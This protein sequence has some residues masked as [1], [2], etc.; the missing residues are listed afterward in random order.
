M[1]NQISLFIML[2]TPVFAY[3]VGAIICSFLE[4]LR[5]DSILTERDNITINRNGL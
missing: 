3:V 1:F 2:L 5:N 4:C